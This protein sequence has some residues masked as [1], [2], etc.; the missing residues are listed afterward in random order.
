[1][2]NIKTVSIVM[3]TRDRQTITQQAITS[4]GLSS[5]PYRVA[6]PFT[7]IYDDGSS[8]D[9]AN[10]VGTCCELNGFN[11]HHNEPSTGSAGAARNNAVSLSAGVFGKTNFLYCSDNDVYFTPAWLKVML[12]A[13]EIAEQHGFKILGGCNHPYHQPEEN[14]PSIPFE[15]AGKQYNI[16][17]NLALA[18]QS[19]LMRWETWEKYGPLEENKGVRQS[20]DWAFTQKVRADGG[21]VGHIKPFVV[22]PTSRTDTFGELIPGHEYIEDYPGVIIE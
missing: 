6:K 9:N 22:I 20:E 17:Q 4:L 21:K 3:I 10:L 12:K 18:S 15:F 13:F 5:Y 19:W 1:M 16:I 8:M 7:F 2:S 11:F 14:V